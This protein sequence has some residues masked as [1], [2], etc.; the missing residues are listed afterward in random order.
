MELPDYFILDLEEKL[1]ALQD[2]RTRANMK[3]E[4]LA[5]IL[6]ISRTRISR[7]ERGEWRKSEHIKTMI[8]LVRAIDNLQLQH[9]P[10]QED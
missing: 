1:A 9:P 3:Q 2:I 10:E 7:W 4:D 5:N 8:N 6:G